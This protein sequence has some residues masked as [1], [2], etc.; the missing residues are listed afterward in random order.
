MKKMHYFNITYICDSN[1]KFCA[2]NVGLID[3]E[4]YTIHPEAF[5]KQLIS[6]NVQDGDI[7]MISGGEPSL[8]P[9]FWNVLDIC[10]KYNCRVELTTNGHIFEDKELAEK[11]YRYGYVNVQISIFGVNE[12]HDN[13]TGCEGNYQRTMHALENFASFKDNTQ[14]SVTVK[15]LLSK[16]TV[17]GNKDA[18]TSIYGRF[19]NKF[20]YSLN[21]LLISDKV[22][23]NRQELLEPYS[24]T[25][26]KLGD[27]VEL[28]N[29]RIYTIPLCLL[30]EKKR[31][32]HL[33]MHHV[34]L[35]KVYSDAKVYEENMDN[36]N[37]LKC[38]LCR[39]EK[40]CDKFLPSYIEYFGEDEISPI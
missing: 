34:D 37:C 16:A 25:L 15:F 35:L 31:N 39:V 32:E 8:S 13:L 30:S 4:G 12:Q 27:F 5:E 17:E 1:C 29:L 6:E 2:A 38:N 10:K 11:L 19:G 28:E 14:F 23:K 36:Y 40:Y 3:Q 24:E 9:Y 33:K 18:Y 22:I 20:N 26:K 7:V 21:A